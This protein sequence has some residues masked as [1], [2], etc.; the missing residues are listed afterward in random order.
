MWVDAH[1]NETDV[2]RVHVG[3]AA[4]VTIDALGAT[5]PGSVQ[6]ITPATAGVLSLLPQ[7]NNTTSNFTKVT[8]VVPVRIAVDLSGEP[9]VLGS[10]ASV[11]IHVAD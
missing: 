5:V 8:Q 2:P 6:A 10:S 7:S 9:G 11:R 3:Q 1:I 4:D